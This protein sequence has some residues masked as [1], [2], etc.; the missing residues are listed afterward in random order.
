M[1]LR[2]QDNLVI[3]ILPVKLDFAIPWEH[4]EVNAK[5]PTAF[6]AAQTGDQNHRSSSS[7]Q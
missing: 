3:Y 1:G 5:E 6:A 4:E 2:S 7:L